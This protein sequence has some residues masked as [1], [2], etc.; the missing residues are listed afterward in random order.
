MKSDALYKSDKKR[1]KG[2]PKIGEE[3]YLVK[4]DTQG[5]VCIDRGYDTHGGV[6]K[7]KEKSTEEERKKNPCAIWIF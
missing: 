7:M 6:D 1:V 3:L 4:N 2:M 5:S